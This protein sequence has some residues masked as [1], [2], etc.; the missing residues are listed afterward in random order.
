MHSETR[1]TTLPDSERTDQE[2]HHVLL[3]DCSQ[4]SKAKGRS[5]EHMPTQQT[6]A[7]T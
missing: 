2:Y 5:L 7:Q 4:G 1:T 6:P 3:E